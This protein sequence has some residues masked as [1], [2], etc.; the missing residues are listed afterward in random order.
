MTGQDWAGWAGL[1][2]TRQ[3]WARMD[4]TGQNKTI[5][6]F[7]HRSE[8]NMT[9]L[10]HSSHDRPG[11]DMTETREKKGFTGQDRTRHN[12]R[13]CE[14]RLTDGVLVLCL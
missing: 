1:G 10:E 13:R 5:P 2:R 14:T 7:G 4:R 9:R 12:S 11:Q 8:Q 3:D 6:D